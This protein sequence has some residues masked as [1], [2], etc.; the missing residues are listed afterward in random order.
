M[1]QDERH[2]PGAI[3]LVKEPDAIHPFAV[4]M[5]SLLLGTRPVHSLL[6]VGLCDQPHNAAAQAR[7]EAGAQRTLYAVAC[8]RLFGPDAASKLRK[9]G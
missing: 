3:K 1:H 6:K 5:L 8:S 2:C 4:A 9:A 7:R